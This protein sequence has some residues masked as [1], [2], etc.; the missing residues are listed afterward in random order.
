MRGRIRRGLTASSRGVSRSNSGRS[1][2]SGGLTTLKSSSSFP[3]RNGRPHR[4]LCDHR[5]LPHRGAHLARRLDRL[6]LLP[7]VPISEACFAALLGTH[8]HGRWLIAPRAKARVTR[9]YRPNTLVLET[10]FETDDGE[11]TLI[12]FMPP[13][14]RNSTIV[15]LL[16]GTRGKLEIDHRA[17]SAFRFWRD[18]TL[19][20]A[21]RGWR[22]ARHRRT[23]HGDLAHAGVSARQRHDYGRRKLLIN[24][25][26]TIPSFSA[27][28]LRTDRCM[29]RLIQRQRAIPAA[30]S[31]AS[32]TPLST[33][34][35]PPSGARNAAA[36]SSGSNHSQP[37]RSSGPLCST[38]TESSSARRSR[39]DTAPGAP[40]SAGAG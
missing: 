12:D 5:R 3:E 30:R 34:R 20:N 4:R 6:V 1:R 14:G 21:A 39:P 33:T 8:E 29:R 2:S 15:R 22:A 32:P 38:N 24:K 28:C 7:A 18:C 40:A 23:G 31:A 13:N 10:R 36:S 35:E 26:D 19:G 9:R 17:H 16:V 11:A 25:D 37:R 27:I